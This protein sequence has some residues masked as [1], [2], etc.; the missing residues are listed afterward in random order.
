[1][2]VDKVRRIVYDFDESVGEIAMFYDESENT[3]IDHETEEEEQ[4]EVAL[5]LYDEYV[6]LVSSVLLNAPIL[7]ELRFNECKPVILVPRRQVDRN[8]LMRWSERIRFFI[9]G[10][11]DI[12]TAALT[13]AL[14]GM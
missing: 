7:S 5:A 11:D 13:E 10:L 2:S 8:D 4:L 6:T 9:V 1:M 3:D 14:A 12:V